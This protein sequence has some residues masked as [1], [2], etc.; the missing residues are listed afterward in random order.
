MKSTLLWNRCDA[1]LVCDHPG[2]VTR[3]RGNVTV[4]HIFQIKAPNVESESRQINGC[5]AVEQQSYFVELP[6]TSKAGGGECAC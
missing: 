5:Y 1:K 3:R 2:N 6:Q 4:N